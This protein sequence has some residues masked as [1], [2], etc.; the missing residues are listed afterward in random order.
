MYK[1][2][3]VAVDLSEESAFLLK[4]RSAWQSVMMRSYPLF[5]WM[6]TSRIFTQGLLT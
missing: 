4:K 3:L 2:V 6:L 1:H 5:M